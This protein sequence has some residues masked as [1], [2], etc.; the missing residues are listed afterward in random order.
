[1]KSEVSSPVSNTT[2]TQMLL[3][4]KTLDSN[5]HEVTVVGSDTVTELKRK[6]CDQTGVDVERQR[7]I[8]QGKVLKDEKSVTAYAIQDGMTIHMVERVETPF[9]RSDNE[10]PP[11]TL[12]QRGAFML[13]E[14]VSMLP[15]SQRNLTRVG[16]AG[17][18][19]L[20]IS[21]TPGGVVVGASIDLNSD[22]GHLQP[23]ENLLSSVF[24][25]IRRG[26]SPRPARRSS[27]TGAARIDRSRSSARSAAGTNGTPSS[28]AQTVHSFSV[29]GVPLARI[30]SIV[31][32]APQPSSS[33]SSSSSSSREQ[34]S[35]YGFT[36][37]R[38]VVDPALRM[39]G[40]RSSSTAGSTGSSRRDGYRNAVREDMNANTVRLRQSIRNTTAQLD[41]FVNEQESSMSASNSASSSGNPSSSDGNNLDQLA[42]SLIGVGDAIREM[43]PVL[44]RMGFILKNQEMYAQRGSVEERAERERELLQ[45]LGEPCLTLSGALQTM[46]ELTRGLSQNLRRIDSPAN[47]RRNQA[48]SHGSGNSRPTNRSARPSRGQPVRADEVPS[49][50]FD[51]MRQLIGA[52]RMEQTPSPVYRQQQAISRPRRSEPSPSSTRPRTPLERGRK[53]KRDG[54]GGRTRNTNSSSTS[55]SSSSKSSKKR[56]TRSSRNESK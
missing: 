53:R 23:V 33:A 39:S 2:N 12:R 36:R 40:H 47:P 32:T 27:S 31:G 49:T 30:S 14:R 44:Q 22:R 5:T 26:G 9:S 19:S 37:R 35:A 4:V 52:S 38:R 43:L 29:T 24:G 3:R 7:L 25:L 10:S 17:P 51:M 50:I 18:S 8:F 13:R 55:P 21:E 28:N 11:P 56:S 41:S 46:S 16:R 15:H 6:V 48:R 54:Q 42:D 45:R 20:Q 34:R 1:M